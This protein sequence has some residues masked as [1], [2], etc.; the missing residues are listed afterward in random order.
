LSIPEERWDKLVSDFRRICLLRRQ[1]RWNEAEML[2]KN[3]LPSRI[4]A[5]SESFDAE[6]EVKRERLDGMFETE[7]RRIEDA[8]LVQEL[9]AARF[10][11]QFVPLI[12]AQVAQEVHSLIAQ[13]MA[14]QDRRPN[15]PAGTV[16]KAAADVSRVAFDDLAGVIDLV[17]AE[18]RIPKS[19]REF[20]SN[21]V[22]KKHNR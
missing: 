21:L 22:Q 10:N 15:K 16:S 3:G 11:E 14:T 1:K 6:L 18:D 9:V 20:E 5:W 4:A 8:F 7:Q 13:E 19:A 2:L 17:L 12:C